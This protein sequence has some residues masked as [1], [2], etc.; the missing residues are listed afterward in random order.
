[1][2]T[3]KYPLLV[4][5][6]IMV[7]MAIAP[8]VWAGGAHNHNHQENAISDDEV[9]AIGQPGKLRDV[10]R[11]IELT[12]GDNMRFIPDNIVIKQGET[13]RI[14]MVNTGN[15]DH[16]F[17]LNTDEEIAEHAEMMRQY[18]N[19]EHG[20]EANAARLKAGQG[21]DI[22]WKFSKAGSFVYACLIPGHSEAG[23]RGKVTVM[24]NDNKVNA[25]KASVETSATEMKTKVVVPKSAAN[26][27]LSSG[28]IRKIDVA[29]G[30]MTIRHGELKN[31][32]MPSMTMMFKVK[33]AAWLTE[34]KEGDKINF[35]AEKS[36]NSLMIM[37]IEKQ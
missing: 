11:T 6:F 35:L 31:L 32:G 19:M 4:T 29:Q 9:V 23:M 36:A 14:H 34:F 8:A 22:I 13:V 10:V 17:I 7:L 20:A 21:G 15:M 25:K 16:E 26:N 1:M 12:M 2:K 27:K 5:T 24:P 30:K 3:T 37:Q 18:P 28:E 33:D